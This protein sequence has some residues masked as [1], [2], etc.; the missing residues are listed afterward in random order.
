MGGLRGACQATTAA[1]RIVAVIVTYNRPALLSRCLESLKEQRHPLA[2]IIVVDDAS[3]GP[4]TAAAVAAFPGV[5][6]VRHSHN[7]GGAAAYCTGIEVA[8]EQGAD[9]VWLMDDD[10]CPADDTCLARLVD[11]LGEDAGI[12][13]PLVLDEADPERLAFPIR[14][15]GTTRFLRQEIS[16]TERIEGF[17]H[18]FNGALVRASVFGAIGLPDPRFVCR[19]DEVDFLLRARRAGIPVRINTAAIFLH[20]GS[21]PEVHPILSGAYY[22]VVPGTATKRHHQ[23]R[24]RGY[25]FRHYGMWRYLVA[26]V[27]RYGCHYLLRWQR[28]DLQGFADW[29]KPTAAG[30]AGTFMREAPPP[31]PRVILRSPATT[32]APPHEAMH[33][34]PR[35]LA[36]G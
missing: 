31:R 21:Q 18:L 26:D 23:F 32:G 22:A 19:G 27:L 7:C 8:L 30:W 4:A 16:A 1:E 14:L 34:R 24:N 13:A 2:G 35:S 12:A 10:G 20:P 33:E 28:P 11:A 17:A 25:I 9:I 15:S 29:L 36:N 5:C 6:H 3:P